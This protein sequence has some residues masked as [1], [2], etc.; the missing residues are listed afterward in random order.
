MEGTVPTTFENDLLQ[1][2]YELRA[3]IVIAFVLVLSVVRLLNDTDFEW[4]AMALILVVVPPMAVV[5][6]GVL[7]DS[8]HILENR[9]HVR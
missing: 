5:F 2:V 6:L 4:L 7:R 3:L 9:L 8:V 1:S